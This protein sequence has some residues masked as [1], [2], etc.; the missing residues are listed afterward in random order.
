[1]VDTEAMEQLSLMEAKE[2]VQDMAVMEDT[3]ERVDP[4]RLAT[5]M[6]QLRFMPVIPEKL[7]VVLTCF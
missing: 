6:L 4:L 2:K 3:A 1:M 5:Q 7:H